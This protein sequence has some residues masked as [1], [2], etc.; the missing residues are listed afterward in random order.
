MAEPTSYYARLLLALQPRLS[1]VLRYIDLDLYQLEVYEQR[2][3]VAF[4]CGLVKFTGQ[5]QQHQFGSQWNNFTMQ[6]KLGFD[7]F[8]NTSNLVPAATL[9]KALEY[10]E[11]EQ[12]VYLLLQGWNANGL[13]Q[14]PF[15]RLADADQ[16]AEDGLRKRIV[17][18]GGMFADDS[19]AL[20]P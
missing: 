7:H 13:L 8:G 11:V 14:T 18:Y 16:Y 12:Q 5:Y 19:L 17:T 15:R 20:Q 2:P 1:P 3:A 10:L 4:P 6:I 9:K